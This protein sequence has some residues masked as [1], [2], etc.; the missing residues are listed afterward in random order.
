MGTIEKPIEASLPV[1]NIVA[2]ETHDQLSH[3]SLGN[4]SLFVAAF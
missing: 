4:N 2:I 3:V 1:E